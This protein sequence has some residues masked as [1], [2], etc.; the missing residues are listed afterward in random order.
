MVPEDSPSTMAE[1]SNSTEGGETAF[2]EINTR[3]RGR[4]GP[5]SGGAW[6]GGFPAL[7]HEAD[8]E[9]GFLSQADRERILKMQELDLTDTSQRNART[10]IRNRVLSAY[11]DC[12]YLRYIHERDRGLIFKKAR[13]AGYDFHF[14]ECFKEFVRFT[15]RGL[16]E[17]AH[18]INIAEILET[19]IAEAE[20]EH[21]TAA[22]ENVT[23]KVDIDVTR[24][25]GDC[26]FDLE[27]R[28]TDHDYLDRSELEVLVISDHKNNSEDIQD[29]ADIDLLDALYYDA[30]QPESDP[31]GYSWEDPDREEA[32]KIVEWLR[33]KF[34][35]YN[36]ETY[37]ELEET[38]DR[39]TAF[40]E[41]LGQELCG[42]LRHL[43][44]E[45][46]NFDSQM[47]TD[48]DLPERD[49]EL[50]HKILWNPDNIDVEEALEQEARPPTSGDEWSPAEDDS[51]QEFIAR[52]E[53]ARE[54]RAGFTSGGEEGRE[55]WEEVLCLADF[56][57]EEWSDYMNEL[58]IDRCLRGLEE[59]FDEEIDTELI[60]GAESWEEIWQSLPKSE[61]E[62]FPL[63]LGE[64]DQ[65]TM[66]AAWEAY[67]EQIDME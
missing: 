3:I 25:P 47:A 36:I 2:G 19:A 7:L 11:F 13:K 24:V 62:D 4:F 52:V 57:K 53:V 6:G 32:E 56:D 49:M 22:G 66:D 8:R 29:A 37:E 31:H 18:D 41:E 17:D 21:A 67:T 15:Y 45:A 10:R 1:E 39:L 38:L 27:Q 35:E 20:Q 12:R 9:R 34:E 46:P 48:A 33:S 60:R 44:R 58:R 23:F 50:L 26:V 59:W 16:L 64:Y 51:L 42:K 55:R 28:Y 14:R 54:S 40:D 30:R 43:S 5:V 63:P 61:A 65:D